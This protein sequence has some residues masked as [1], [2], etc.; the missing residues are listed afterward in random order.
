MCPSALDW[1][2][3]CIC[4]NGPS[5]MGQ[6]GV[7]ACKHSLYKWVSD[8]LLSFLSLRWSVCFLISLSHSLSLGHTFFRTRSRAAHFL[9]F[10]CVQFRNTHTHTHTHTLAKTARAI[11][12]KRRT[13]HRLMATHIDR[14]KHDGRRHGDGDVEAGRKKLKWSTR[15]EWIRI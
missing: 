14:V 3:L 12:A 8:L 6:Q 4:A 13:E 10:H 9:Y 7:G 5:Q 2:I 15:E 11:N 1:K